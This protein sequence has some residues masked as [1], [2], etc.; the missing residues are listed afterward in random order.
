M[1]LKPLNKVIRGPQQAISLKYAVKWNKRQTLLSVWGKV[2]K[3][4]L[5]YYAR[6][7]RKCPFAVLEMGSSIALL[8]FWLGSFPLWSQG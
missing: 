6:C 1:Q 8:R 7:G 5:P 2:D 3:L 4:L